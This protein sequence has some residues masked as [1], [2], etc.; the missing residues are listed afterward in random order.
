MVFVKCEGR[1]AHLESWFWCRLRS[2]PL[3]LACGLNHVADWLKLYLCFMHKQG[4][5]GR[6]KRN[7]VCRKGGQALQKL[8]SVSV[9][10]TRHLDI[11]FHFFP[12]AS[13]SPMHIPIM[14]V[15]DVPNVAFDITCSS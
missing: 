7:D 1:E 2:F 9:E 11:K 14:P 13:H 3:E 8:G 5:Q 4:L 12:S 10:R 6:T 15:H